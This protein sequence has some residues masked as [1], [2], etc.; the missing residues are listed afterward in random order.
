MHACVDDE[1][2]GAQQGAVQATDAAKCIVVVHTHLVR[3]LLGVQRPAFERIEH[4]L[5]GHS[6]VRVSMAIQFT[7]QVLPPSSENAC[8]KRPELGVML[9]QT[10]RTRTV[11]PP[12]SS[13]S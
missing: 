2:D 5:V 8:S 11:R 7:S 12:I 6:L 3:Q 4:G 13:R 1:A 9:D 10:L